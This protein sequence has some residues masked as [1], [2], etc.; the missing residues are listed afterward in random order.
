LSVVSGLLSL[1]EPIGDSLI[2]LP[3]GTVRIDEAC[4]GISSLQSTVMATLFIGHVTL[5]RLRLQVAL[6][7]AG[8]LLAILGN[9]GRSLFLS[10]MANAHGVKSLDRYHCAAGWSILLFTGSGIALLAWALAK[11][12][13]SLRP[14][15]PDSAKSVS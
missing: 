7:V 3:N 1:V 9:V 2:H 8:I 14:P 6:F 5:R 12:E 10:L 13:S 15:R 11:L 4:S